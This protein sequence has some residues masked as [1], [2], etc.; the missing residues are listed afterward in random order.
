MNY[1]DFEKLYRSDAVV[2]H[3]AM[4]LLMESGRDLIGSCPPLVRLLCGWEDP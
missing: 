3:L 1:N 4:D 2:F